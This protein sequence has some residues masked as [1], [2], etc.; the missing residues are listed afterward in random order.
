MSVLRMTGQ[1]PESGAASLPVATLV[2]LLRREAEPLDELP[3][4]VAGPLRAARVLPVG[5]PAVRLE[6]QDAE[7]VRADVHDRG[8]R[9]R[10]RGGT[11]GRRCAPASR[12]CARAR[13]E[14]PSRPV[15]ARRRRRLPAP[16][17]EHAE[18]RPR[19]GSFWCSTRARRTQREPAGLARQLHHLHR[20]R[21]DVESDVPAVIDPR[22]LRGRAGLAAAPRPL[23]PVLDRDRGGAD[24]RRSLRR[25]RP[26][27]G[28]PGE[29]PS[30]THQTVPA[31]SCFTRSASLATGSRKR[32]AAFPT[33]SIA[34]SA[35]EAPVQGRLMWSAASTARSFAARGRRAFRPSIA[36]SPSRVKMKSPLGRSSVLS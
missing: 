9:A 12:G 32:V 5:V 3:E 23:A 2:R 33:S 18:E 29:T 19:P 31:R 7:A 21:A 6:R 35:P 4:E 15:R 22:G 16:L 20:L 1:R 36:D 28:A 27:S 8:G 30:A 13:A 10:R 11:G 25:S 14:R 26:G 24:R 34:R 17:P